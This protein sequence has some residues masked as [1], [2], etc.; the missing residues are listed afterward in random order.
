MSRH[1]TQC[2]QRHNCILGEYKSVLSVH[3]GSGR[4]SI[5][6]GMAEVTSHVIHVSRHC[7]K[8]LTKHRRWNHRNFRVEP[9]PPPP[10]HSTNEM[11]RVSMVQCDHYPY[12]PPP[13][14][15]LLK[16]TKTIGSGHFLIFGGFWV[17][18][19]DYESDFE[20]CAALMAYLP[21]VPV[22]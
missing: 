15:P 21:S 20:E 6:I 18:K 17:K 14:P 8:H 16:G 7:R 13:P 4:C 5:I 3:R 2:H 10:P 12:R 19:L 22:S 11:Y 9:P 1:W